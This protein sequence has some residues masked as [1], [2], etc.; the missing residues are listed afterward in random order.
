MKSIFITYNKIIYATIL[1]VMKPK[2]SIDK[3]TE[4]DYKI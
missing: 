4:E 1:K 3:K 2:L